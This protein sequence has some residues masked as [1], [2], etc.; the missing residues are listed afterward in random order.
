MPLLLLFFLLTLLGQAQEVEV[1]LFEGGEGVDFYR[2]AARR[3]EE[4]RPGVS[5]LLEADPAM[6]DKMRM[7]VL[8]GNLPE[9]SNASIDIWALI[10]NGDV[11]PLDSWLDQKAVDGESTWRETFLPGSL[12]QFQKDG[13]TYGIPLVYVVWSVYYNKT[14]FAEHGW[15]IPRTWPEF[16]SLCEKIQQTSTAPIAFQGRYPFY[17]KALVEH[18]YFQ[19]VGRERYL[20][21]AQ[22]QP[23][24]F[25]N[26]EMIDSL[27]TLRTLSQQHFQPG[28]QGMS[29]TEAQLEFFQGRAAMLFCGSWLFSEMRDNIPEGFELGSFALPLP[30]SDRADPAAQYATSGYFFVFK[31][32]AHP[33]L[34]AEFLKQMTSPEVAGRFARERGTPVAIASANDSLHP[35]VADLQH[36]LEQ[37]KETFGPAPGRGLKGLGQVWNDNLARLLAGEAEPQ[38]LVKDMERET[39]ALR[40]KSL[41]PDAIEVRHPRKTLAFLLFLMLGVALASRSQTRQ[42]DAPSVKAGGGVTFLFIGPALLAFAL[43]FAIPSF[44]ALGGTLF[45]WDGLGKPE[46]VGLFH[47]KW[48]LLESDLFWSSLGHNLILMLV[49]AIFVIPLALF[50]AYLLH[51]RLAGQ[52]LFRVVF[53]FPNLLGVAGVLLWQ[54]LYNPQIGPIN[55]LLTSLG[56]SFFENFAWLAPGNL[57]YALIPMAVWSATGFNMVLFL[58]AMQAVPVSLYE[59]AELN[60]ADDV[61]KFFYITLPH[62]R[63]TVMVALVLM[64]I[65]GMKAFEAIWLLTNQSPTS[66]THVVGTLMVRALFVEQRIGQAAALATLLFLVVLV[67]SVVT[68]RLSEEKS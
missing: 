58:A 17:A 21:L 54:Q 62:I 2:Y 15:E 47:L 51:Q 33:D 38:V 46:F 53:F 67:G 52:R 57:Y 45:R 16:E 5:V 19:Q 59:A 48:L 23:G 13:K 1:S 42:L 34:G 28:F 61:Q 68:N 39:A 25:D 27:G 41:S 37:I 6:A 66:Q 35:T 64:V 7:R 32:S 50:L 22:G 12:S 29:H 31:S 65:G 60:G 4:S 8:E 9:V 30:V 55:K 10:D 44:L 14:L 56:L 3:L 18:T 26:P 43:F 40:R 49:P 20:E 36:Q 11:Q 24:C 63:H